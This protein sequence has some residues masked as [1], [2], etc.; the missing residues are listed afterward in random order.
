[1]EGYYFLPNKETQSG[2]YG[3]ALKS[4]LGFRLVLNEAGIGRP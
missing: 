4:V 2:S 1:M 3:F